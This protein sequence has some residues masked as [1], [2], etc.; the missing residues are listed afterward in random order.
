MGQMTE[1]RDTRDK[2]ADEGGRERES[3]ERE[4]KLPDHFTAN[5][6]QCDQGPNKHTVIS[7]IKLDFSTTI[8][9]AAKDCSAV[10]KS[11]NE[12]VTM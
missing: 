3:R 8:N 7:L 10:D 5:S 12:N 4:E 2:V 9:I 6:H 1:R 11:M